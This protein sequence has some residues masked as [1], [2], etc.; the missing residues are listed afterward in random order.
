MFE[1]K[2]SNILHVHM[3]IFKAT[4]CILLKKIQYQ[5]VSTT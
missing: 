5:P 2:E 4:K 1:L 3:M